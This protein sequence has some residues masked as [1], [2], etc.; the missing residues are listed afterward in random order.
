[1]KHLVDIDFNK[2]QALNMVIQVLT[3]NPSAPNV[4]QTY[5][6]SVDKT[7]YTYTSTGWIDLGY[8]HPNV[9]G[10]AISI[11]PTGATVIASFQTNAEGHVTAVTTR[12]MT[13]ADLGFTGSPTANDY[14]HPAYTSTDYAK[15]GNLKIISAIAI[16]NGHI[17][18]VTETDLSGD[19][20]G[21]LVINDGSTT[22]TVRTWS[23]SQLSQK[24]TDLDNTIAGA[25]V[26][27]G[28]Y[29]AGTNTPNLT[30]PAVGAVL[31]GYTYTVT[32]AGT[33]LGENMEPGDMLIAEVDDPT[34]ATDWTIVNKNV[35]EILYATETVAGTIEIATQAEVDAGADNTRAV[36]PGR[37]MTLLTNRAAA[38]V[39]KA[40]IGNGAATSFDL[41]HGLASMDVMVQVYDDLGTS[42]TF[43]EEV[44]TIMKR[45]SNS[46][47]R[48]QVNNAIAANELRV[49]IT[50]I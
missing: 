47:V 12:A 10:G 39:Y 46:T 25:L 23:A 19:A 28:G 40:H 30:T 33:F 6:N 41:L 44:G 34:V 15:S 22:S 13:L 4:G 18:S 50:K 24:F 16:E 32:V 5:Y 35:D 26:Y 8:A 14:T 36:T 7:V 2:N 48:I 27:K 17:Q 20:I 31:Q 38:N 43:G 11:A 37:L 42:D 3:S 21:A 9:A 29:D 1:M 49:L 45:V